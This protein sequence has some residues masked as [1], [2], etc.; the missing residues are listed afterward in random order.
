MSPYEIEFRPSSFVRR[1]CRNSLDLMRR[2]VAS[3][4]HTLGRF[5]NCSDFFVCFFVVVFFFQFSL[6]WDPTG[7]KISKTLHSSN[8]SKPKKFKLVL[9]V[10]PKSP[11]KITIGIFENLYFRVLTV[12]FSLF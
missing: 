8:K 12:L 10:P 3:P 5:L 6:I 11:H 1:L 9:N 4:E 7:V 2:V